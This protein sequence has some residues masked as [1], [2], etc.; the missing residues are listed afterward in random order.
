MFMLGERH[1]GTVM[2]YV[3]EPHAA[4]YHFTSALPTQLMREL[5]PLLLP[6]VEGDACVER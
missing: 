1:F 3:H 2:A 4:D 5:A 6:L